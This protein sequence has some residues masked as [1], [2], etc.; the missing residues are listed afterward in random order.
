MS[1][2]ERYVFAPSIDWNISDKTLLNVNLYYQND[3]EAGNNTSIPEQ[4]F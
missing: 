3:P 1:G 4:C 2:N